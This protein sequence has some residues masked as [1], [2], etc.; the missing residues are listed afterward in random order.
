MGPPDPEETA[1]IVARDLPDVA[2]E[3]ASLI[4]E[5]RSLEEH[6]Y[7]ILKHRLEHAQAAVDAALIEARRRVRINEGRDR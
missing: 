1:R 3:L 6:E 4:G 5:V 2:R 7:A